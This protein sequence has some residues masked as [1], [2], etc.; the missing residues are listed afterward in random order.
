MNDDEFV[1][2][3]P[4]WRKKATNDI[5]L[6]DGHLQAT[7]YQ[8]MLAIEMMSP[9]IK[10]KYNRNMNEKDIIRFIYALKGGE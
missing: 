2:N 1:I 8:I 7:E 9:I 5:V 3:D 4:N 6:L 10:K